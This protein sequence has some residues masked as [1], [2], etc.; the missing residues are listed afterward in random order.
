ME[1]DDPTGTAE[2]MYV[3]DYGLFE[4]GE[5]ERV[6]GI[7]GYLIQTSDVGNILVDLGFPPRYA[8]DPLSAG[9]SDGLDEFGQ[10]VALAPENLPSAQLARIGLTPQDVDVLLLTHTDIDHIGDLGNW[11]HVKIAVGRPERS[12]DQPRELGVATVIEWPEEAQ[13]L[14]LEED[15]PIAQGVTALYTPGHSPG[16]LS[17]LVRLPATGPVLITGDAISRPAELEEGFGN[18]F[19]PEQA[20]QS[21]EKLVAIADQEGAFVIYGHDPQRWPTLRKAPHYYS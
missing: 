2:R 5:G 3:L 15:T 16:H 20:A 17:L 21:A 7:Q 11:G 19:D 12:F 14:L 9:Q 1:I 4:V 10:V 13:Y 18:A 6:I 8:D